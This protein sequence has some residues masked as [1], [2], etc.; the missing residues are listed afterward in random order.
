MTDEQ[1]LDGASRALDRGIRN[2]K[3]YAMVGLPTETDDDL[4]ALVD[5]TIGLRSLMY[6][7]QG[8]NPGNL[9]LSVNPFI[10]KP[11]TPFQWSRMEPMREIKRRVRLI[12]KGIGKNAEVKVEN[13]RSAYLEG[14]LSRGGREMSAFLAATYRCEGDWK[15]A[16]REIGL[17]IEG[18]L[19]ERP[20]R[21]A[22]QPW[23]FISYDGEREKLERELTRALR[24]QSDPPY[25]AGGQEP[26]SVPGTGREQ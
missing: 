12:E 14:I 22:P 20:D 13:Y 3:V 1:I 16:A 15:R 21:L 10:P 26:S 4:Q 24:V 23:D 25:P 8:G 5:L 6:R 17:D 2:L 7:R 11:L 18:Y 9:G 19:A